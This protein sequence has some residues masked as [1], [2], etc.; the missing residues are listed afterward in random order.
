MLYR[1]LGSTVPTLQEGAM[2]RFAVCM[3]LLTF[4]T[5]ASKAAR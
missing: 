1:D 4:C 2:K 3:L 5:N